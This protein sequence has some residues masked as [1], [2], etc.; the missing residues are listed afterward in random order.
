MGM[1]NFCPGWFSKAPCVGLDRLFLSSN[2][3]RRRVAVA[4]CSECKFRDDCRDFALSNNILIG[5]WGG[6]TG[7][8]LQRLSESCVSSV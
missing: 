2:T 7:P 6:L 4:I 3:A 8:E 1:S 5:V